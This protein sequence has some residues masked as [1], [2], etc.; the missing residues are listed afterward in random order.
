M[1]FESARDHLREML[2][3]EC[4]RARN[5]GCTRCFG[6]AARVEWTVD[7]TVWCGRRHFARWGRRR[8]LSARHTIDVVVEENDRQI[9]VATAAVEKM[10][11]AD[12][13]AVAVSCNDNDV[14]F[15]ACELDARCKRNCSPVCCVYGVKVHIAR[16]ARG[17]ANAGDN[18][19]IVLCK[20]LRTLYRLCNAFQCRAVAAA[21]APEV[22]EAILTKILL[23]AAVNLRVC[24]HIRVHAR[25][26]S[27]I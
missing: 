3:V 12:G 10:I 19:G 26:S 4:R 18:D 6:D 9:D 20:A 13:G 5:V 17:T 2:D 27:L 1:I 14:E 15:R 11:A 22:G 24:C 23:K 8:G 25:T 21:R 7:C 16:A